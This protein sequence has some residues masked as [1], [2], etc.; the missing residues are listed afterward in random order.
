MSSRTMATTPV[1]TGVRRRLKL[2]LFVMVIFMSW[3]AYVLITQHGTMSDRESDLREAT[4]KLSDVNVQTEA[5]KQEIVKLH[6]KEY[7]SELARKEQGYGYPGEIP[8]EINK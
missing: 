7:I 3:A 1:M 2:L 8:L 5:L 6:D 4:K